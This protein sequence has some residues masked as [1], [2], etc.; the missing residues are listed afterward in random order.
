MFIIPEGKRQASRD[1]SRS[2]ER[3]MTNQIPNDSPPRALRLSA[4]TPHLLSFCRGGLGRCYRKLRNVTFSKAFCRPR[5]GSE[6]CPTCTPDHTGSAMQE[7]ARSCN[8]FRGSEKCALLQPF[9]VSRRGH[10]RRASGPPRPERTFRSM[11]RLGWRLPPPGI[12]CS[13]GPTVPSFPLTTD[14]NHSPTRCSTIPQIA[15]I[16]K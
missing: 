2:Q 5:N 10:R 8:V 11:E 9:L 7:N 4:S 15:A 6:A 3:R 16:R 13:C 14:H 1:E 12:S